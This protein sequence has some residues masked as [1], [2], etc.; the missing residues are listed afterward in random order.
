MP[1]DK[2]VPVL[3]EVLEFTYANNLHETCRFPDSIEE[4][5]YAIFHAIAMSS[6]R[7]FEVVM[8]AFNT[9]IAKY[10]GESFLRLIAHHKER[11]A[12][13]FYRQYSVEYSLGEV[14]S[15]Y[16]KPCNI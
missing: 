10:L 16:T 6:L 13:D 8:A 3:I 9:L 5:V 14:I 1:V 12:Q 7:S 4:A 11:M 15:I 2:A